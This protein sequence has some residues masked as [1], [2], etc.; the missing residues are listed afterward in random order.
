[1]LQCSLCKNCLDD[2]AQNVVVDGVKSVGGWSQVP[3]GSV[4]GQVL[5]NISI[6]GQDY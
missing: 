2:E 3:Q 5:F 6:P 4:L 1:M